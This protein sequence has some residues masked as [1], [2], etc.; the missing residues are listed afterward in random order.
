[1]GGHKMS[2]F[3]LSNITFLFFSLDFEV[4]SNLDMFS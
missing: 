2:S 1:M 4:K 3:S